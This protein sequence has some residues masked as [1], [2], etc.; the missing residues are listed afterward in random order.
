MHKHDLDLIAEYAGGSLR[1]DSKARALVESCET[2]AAE[3]QAQQGMLTEL[4]GIGPTR[5]TDLERAQ[6]RRD[7]WTDLRAHPETDPVRGV[8]SGWWGWAFGTAAIVFAAVALVGVMNNIGGGGD[9]ATQT[10]SEIASGLNSGETRAL[11]DAGG[12]DGDAGAESADSTS[13]ASESPQILSD[14]YSDT[15][16]LQ[17]ARQVRAKERANDDSGYYTYGEAELDCLEESG[18]IDHELIA[19]FETVT[20]LLVAVPTGI[21]LAEAPVAFVEPEFCTVVHIED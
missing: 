19:G 14:R 11:E 4:R 5:M 2:C 8:A 12:G 13:P 7:L 17:I 16:Y 18:L 10:F 21:D 1:D 15:P 9:A 6:L 20:D 3:F